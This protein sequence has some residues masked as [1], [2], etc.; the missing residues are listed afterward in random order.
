MANNNPLNDNKSQND[1]SQNELD[2]GL[3]Q[4]DAV[5]PRKPVQPSESLLD[6]AKG[7]KGLFGRK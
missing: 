5:T 7:L 1:K 6:K 3:G 4:E 2:L